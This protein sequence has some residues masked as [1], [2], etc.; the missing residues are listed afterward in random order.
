M[1][2]PQPFGIRVRMPENDP[3]CAPHL[4]GEAWSSERWYVTEAERDS[5]YIKM[6]QQPPYYRRGDAPSVLLEKI[7]R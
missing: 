2:K 4:L 6:Q 1:S 5:A 7:E 3:F